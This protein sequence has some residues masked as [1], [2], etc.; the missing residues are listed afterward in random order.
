MKKKEKKIRK[1]LN[2]V[3]AEFVGIDP[4]QNEKGKQMARYMLDPDQIKALEDFKKA[5]NKRKF[6]I[7]Q[8]KL[9]KNGNVSSSVEKLQAPAT[10]V[11][12]NFEVTRVSKNETTNQE[13]IRYEKKK[14]TI[15]D[16]DFNKILKKIKNLVKPVKLNKV[17]H[18][19]GLHADFD[20]LI[21]TDVHIGMDTNSRERAMYST[22]W[23]KETIFET[24]ELMIQETLASQKSNTLI[25]DDLGDFLDG[26]NGQTTRGGHLLPQNMTNE[27]AFDIGLEFKIKLVRGLANHYDHILINNICNDNHAGSFGYFVNKASKEV[28]ELM[29]PDIVE[30]VNHM[31]FINHYIFNEV[32]FVLTHGKDDQSLKFGFKPQLDTKQIEKIDRYCKEY[33]VYKDS[34]LVVFIKGDSHQAL[35]DLAGSDDFY[36]FNYPALSPSSEWVQ[37]NF[38]RGRRGFV[39]ESY[40]DQRHKQEIVFL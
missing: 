5:P 9:D 13:W 1:W 23:N 28:L 39:L 21:Y 12:E 40:T 30:V 26:F 22:Q 2:K 25:I 36:Y 20:K 17:Y 38:K 7:T 15:K 32:A 27:E 14:E 6:E 16:F 33:N 24:L 4:K 11:P 31:K 34:K 37:N 8:N 18:E 29:F 35:F 10:K 3:Q 19:H